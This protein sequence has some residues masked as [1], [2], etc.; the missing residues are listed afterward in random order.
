MRKYSNDSRN[1]AMAAWAAWEQ[2]KFWEMH[3][4]LF[5]HAPE[6][7]RPVLDR[8]A[9]ELGL[10]MARFK[11]A[12]DGMT[13]LPE[14]QKNLDRIHDLDV[15]STPTVIINGRMYKGAQPY[16]NY[17]VIVEEALRGKDVGRLIRFFRAFLAWSGPPEARAEGTSFGLGKVPLYVPVPAARPTNE[18]KIG[19]MAPDFTLPS[20]DGADVTLSSFRGAKNV[21]LTFL[22][23]AFTPV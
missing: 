18:P 10:D 12:M 20:V 2:G 17:K 7:E 23:A 21:L 3:D 16:E 15:W 22:P 13:H 11:S 6:L 19:E 4:L 1:A 5:Q 9:G 14:L 8:L